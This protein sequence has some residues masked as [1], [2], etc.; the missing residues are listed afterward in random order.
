LEG[1][2]FNYFCYSLLFWATL[3]IAWLKQ[4]CL[5]ESIEGYL[6]FHLARS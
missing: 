4:I 3:C 6:E 5:K 2:H 1:T